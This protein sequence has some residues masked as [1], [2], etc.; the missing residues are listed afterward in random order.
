MGILGK[1][2][3]KD[4]STGY[5]KTFLRQ[6]QTCLDLA[7]ERGVTIVVNAGGL[8]PAGLASELRKINPR[9]LI[10]YVTGDAL[11][12]D[13]LTANAYLG[14][15]GIA[16]CITAGANVV[17]TGRVTDAS[18]VVGPA[19]LRPLGRPATTWTR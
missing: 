7:L 15:F 1:D 18:L 19:I 12:T 8:N 14:A 16:D 4:P 11:P 9:A 3:A 2:R 5:A 10:G 13:G 6:M 17:V